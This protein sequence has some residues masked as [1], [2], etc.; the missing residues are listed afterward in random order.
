M[1]HEMRHG[2]GGCQIVYFALPSEAPEALLV[3]SVNSMINCDIRD[4]GI[5]P[6][7]VEYTFSG[8]YAKLPNFKKPRMAASFRRLVTAVFFSAANLY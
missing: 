8:F 7:I 3:S 6:R 2:Y 4:K 1:E 5:S